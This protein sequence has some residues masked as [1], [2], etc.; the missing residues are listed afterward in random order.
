[1]DRI[2]ELAK[3]GMGYTKVANT[4]NREG[5]KRPE[6]TPWTDKTVSAYC[7][8]NGLRQKPYYGRKGSRGKATP[9]TIHTSNIMTIVE[10]IVTSNLNPQTKEQVIKS[11]FV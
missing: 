7:V 2:L 8:K 6:G 11:L 1:M 4:L 10:D 5:I 3:T 9:K